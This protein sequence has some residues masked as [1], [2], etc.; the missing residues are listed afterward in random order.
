M[1]SE[2]PIVFERDEVNEPALVI[3]IGDLNNLNHP[4]IRNMVE[5]FGLS[6][7]EFGRLLRLEFEPLIG[8]T[9]FSVRNSN[10]EKIENGVKRI[11]GSSVGEIEVSD[12]TL[13]PSVVTGKNDMSLHFKLGEK[14]GFEAIYALEGEAELAFPKTVEPV[15]VGVYIASKEREFVKLTPGTLAIIPAPTAN[16]WSMVGENFR[17]LYICQP[18]WNPTFVKQALDK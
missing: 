8:P 7:D 14:K 18:R 10:G 9:E 12:I 11:A 6:V 15:A 1:K 4:K 5:P 16:G 2:V 3:E 17:F 13:Y